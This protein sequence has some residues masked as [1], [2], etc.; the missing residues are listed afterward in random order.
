MTKYSETTMKLVS[1]DSYVSGV[2]A[3]A[4]LMFNEGHGDASLAIM[5]KSLTEKQRQVAKEI[6]KANIDHYGWE[7]NKMCLAKLTH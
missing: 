1:E 2:L 4:S 7:F 6:I 3:A 5:K